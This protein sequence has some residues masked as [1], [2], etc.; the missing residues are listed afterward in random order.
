MQVNMTKLGLVVYLT[1]SGALVEDNL[2]DLE[3]G[4]AQ[5]DT[6]GPVNMVLDMRDAPVLD[7]KGLEF[8][9]DLSARLKDAGGSLR[10]SNVNATC[11]TI[12]R[13]T[14]LDGSVVLCDDFDEDLGGLPE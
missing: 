2:H 4:F 3:K 5:A 13:I 1:P 12:L 6:E 10:L 14:R 8:L 7:S 11:R 9:L